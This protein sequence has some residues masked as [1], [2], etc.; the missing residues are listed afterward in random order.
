MWLGRV[1]C[2][3]YVAVEVFELLALRARRRCRLSDATRII[4]IR[5]CGA[6]NEVFKV[7]VH[8]YGGGL[9]VD[10][11]RK[12]IAS[13]DPTS[14]SPQPQLQMA[15]QK[16]RI[17][18]Q[19]LDF[20]IL[21]STHIHVLIHVSKY[22]QEFCCSFPRAHAA[23]AAIRGHRDQ[24]AAGRVSSLKASNIATHEYM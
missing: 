19:R 1:R 7:A 15:A 10:F 17:C 21:D 8:H 22:N 16:E 14:Y 23:R 3:V 12:R 13:F 11:S 5:G 20:I 2:R 6:E 4:Q 9:P 24:G 18:R